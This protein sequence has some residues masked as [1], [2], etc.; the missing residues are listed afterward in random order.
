MRTYQKLSQNT[1]TANFPCQFAYFVM[2]PV[3]TLPKGFPYQKPTTSSNTKPLARDKYHL[4]LLQYFLKIAFYLLSTFISPWTFQKLC[5]VIK[6][7]QEYDEEV[8]P[9]SFISVLRSGFGR[10]RLQSP[11]ANSKQ[12]P[13]NQDTK[14]ARGCLVREESFRIANEE[15]RKDSGGSP[16]LIRT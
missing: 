4:I 7:S 15:H 13:M 1:Y 14:P 2:K 11:L 8:P 12:K 5:S 3:R 9:S 16:T 10:P 6:N